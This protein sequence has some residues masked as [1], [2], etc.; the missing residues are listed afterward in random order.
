MVLIP[1]VVAQENRRGVI[2]SH[3]N[4]DSTVV[5]KISNRHSASRERPLKYRPTLR[6]DILEALPRVVKEHQR[7]LILDLAVQALDEIIRVAVGKKQIEITVIVIV[8]KFQSPAAHQTGC[9]ADTGR[10]RLI[11]ECFVVV[12]LVYRKHLTVYI[13]YEQIHPP[14]F[15]EVRGIHAHAGASP[16]VGAVGHARISRSIFESA[17]ASIH[18]EKVRHG[19]I[20]NKEVEMAVVVE[21]SS[22]YAP[23]LPEII[24]DARRLA[25]ICESSIAIVVK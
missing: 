12:V 7:F 1:Y 3:Q 21:I 6:T 2:D 25:D 24:G 19:V 14:I 20:A 16:A 11:V 13:G 9:G 17:V 5:V 15:V 4:I 23:C 10:S 22:H 8:K 18:E